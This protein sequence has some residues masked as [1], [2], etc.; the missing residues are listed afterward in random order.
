MFNSR[1]YRF[2]ENNSSVTLTYTSWDS[3]AICFEKYSCEISFPTL[4]SSLPL[5]AEY[6]LNNIHDSRLSDEILLQ[7]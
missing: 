4:T 7:E 2:S 3:V 6:I 5:D 1:V